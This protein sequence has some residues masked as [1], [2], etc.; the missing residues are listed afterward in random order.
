VEFKVEQPRIILVPLTQTLSGLLN[1]LPD[2]PEEIFRRPLR[3]QLDGKRLDGHSGLG[4]IRD[5]DLPHREHVLEEIIDEFRVRIPDKRSAFHPSSNFEDAE[6]LQRS[7]GFANGDPARLELVDQLSLGGQFVP[8]FQLF[9]ENGFL[10]LIDDDTGDAV[11]G[12]GLEHSFL[13]HLKS[14]LAFIYINVSPLSR[15]K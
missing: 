9:L 10:D 8:G 6:L 4:E 11:G 13:A 5:L 1:I 7:Q 12:D 2:L 14:G 15:K 3:S